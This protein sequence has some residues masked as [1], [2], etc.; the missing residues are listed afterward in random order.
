MHTHIRDFFGKRKQTSLKVFIMLQLKLKCLIGKNNKILACKYTFGQP[1][2]YLLSENEF[3][4]Q[5]Q[6]YL[7]WVQCLVKS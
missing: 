4:I 3:K 1:I 6:Y 5:I 2:Y 7:E